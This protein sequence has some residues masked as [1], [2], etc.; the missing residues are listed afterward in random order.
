M[1]NVKYES[2][3]RWRLLSSVFILSV[4]LQVF[5]DLKDTGQN[6]AVPLE[7]MRAVLLLLCDLLCEYW[8]QQPHLALELWGR[9]CKWIKYEKGYLM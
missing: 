5:I 2:G 7:A 3:Y 1:H 6:R 4:L 8:H 9:C